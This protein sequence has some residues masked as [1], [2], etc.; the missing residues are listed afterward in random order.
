MTTMKA[1]RIHDYGGPEVLHYEDV[2]R[3]SPAAEELLIRV[4]AVGVNPVDWKLRSGQARKH[5]ELPMPAILG[6]D[7]AGVVEQIGSAVDGFKSGDAVYAMLGLTGA[8]AQYIVAKATIVAPKPRTLD[9]IEAASVPL[10]ALTAWQGLFE[11]GKLQ[12]GQTVLVH[13]AAGGVGGFAVQLATAR[14]A[15][16]IG[17]TSA[18]NAEF[19]RSLGAAQTIDYR[20]SPFEGHL[21]GVDLV[22]D[23]IGG[24]IAERSIGVLKPGGVLVQ[25]VPGTPATAQKAATANVRTIAVR[26][27]PDG[28]QLREIAALIDSGKLKT[29]IAAV[30]PLAEAGRAHEM[31]REGHTRGKIVLTCET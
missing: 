17:T 6:G 14:G 3:P 28:G 23:L 2:Q 12:K 4:Q 9:H 1:L 27:H 22:L 7:V 26:V 8:Y 31:S 25:I 20:S 11:H 24:E 19:V 16:V 30:F 29:S 13:A 18:K 10:A 15:R 21:S 5:L